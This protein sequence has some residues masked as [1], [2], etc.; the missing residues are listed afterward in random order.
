VTSQEQTE[1]LQEAVTR[2]VR[3][4]RYP[5]AT[6]Q[7]LADLWATVQSMVSYAEEPRG[8]FSSYREKVR[9]LD[10]DFDRQCEPLRLI[11]GWPFE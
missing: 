9:Q 6:R 10:D 2:I 8:N 1:D 4:D 3:N 11:V 5:E 7:R